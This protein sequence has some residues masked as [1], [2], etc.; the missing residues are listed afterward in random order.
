MTTNPSESVPEEPAALAPVAGVVNATLK[1]PS[2]REPPAAL[3]DVALI[4]ASSIAAAA[5][6][7][8]SSWHELVQK[9][10]AP[11]PVIRRP[12]FTRWRL[13]DVRMHLAKMASEG[14]D[15]DAAKNLKAQ[16]TKASRKA[17]ERRARPGA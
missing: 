7:S 16:A 10:E 1:Q 15:H 3:A 6:M 12:R 13:A 4:D 5:C 17:A 14:V 9:G 2:R 11:Q 8:L